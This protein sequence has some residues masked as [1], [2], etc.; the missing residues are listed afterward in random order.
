MFLFS[1]F[2]HV[3][4]SGVF[5]LLM[6]AKVLEVRHELNK[7][8]II[9]V[10]FFL[11]FHNILLLYY[12][13]YISL[14][15]LMCGFAQ[16]DRE[17]RMCEKKGKREIYINYPLPCSIRDTRMRRKKASQFANL[18]ILFQFYF[19]LSFASHKL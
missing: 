5:L 11:C 14:F 6:S 4:V 7:L 10:F 13:P 8:K 18:F 15:C 19:L 12:H 9:V 1:S 3:K 17:K 2:V 16:T